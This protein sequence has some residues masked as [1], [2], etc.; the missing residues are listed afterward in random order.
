MRN[1]RE[2]SKRRY[3]KM[4]KALA[5]LVVL[6]IFIFFMLIFSVLLPSFGRVLAGVGENNVTVQTLLEVGNVYPE[7]LS[8]VINDGQAI[9]LVPN[10]TA[11]V[12][13]FAVI[14]DYNG[15]NDIEL[16]NATFFDNT[17]GYGNSDDNN[18]HY[19]NAS[20]AL[21]TGYGDGFE[22][23]ANCSFTVW[24]YANNETWNA[25]VE[26]T[27]N[28][29]WT[30]IESNTTT[31]NVLLAFVLPDTINY[32]QVNATEVSLQRIANVTNAGNVLVNLSLSGYAYTVGDGWAMNCSVGNVQ[33]ISIGY[34]QYNLTDSNTSVLTLAEYDLIHKNLTSDPVVNGFDLFQRQNDTVQYVDDTNSTYWRIYVPI[35]VAG[36]C[37]G[38]IV[39]GAVQASE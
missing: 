1:K 36:N 37:T 13:V 27:D 11:N 2:E 4:Q 34:E 21:D 29:S 5:G 14:R 25:T 3:D 8:V 17:V 22:V 24:Y 6:E 30:D 28:R 12:S 39:F 38:N 15:E 10:G 7:I 32:G 33:N 26:V 16:A 19:T 20:C 18:N 23:G 9:D 35:G 31:M